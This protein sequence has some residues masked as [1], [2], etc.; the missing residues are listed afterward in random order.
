MENLQVLQKIYSIIYTI[1][2]NAA[3]ATNKQRTTA[4]ITNL[5]NKI[6]NKK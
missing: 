4:T 5:N 3:T 2:K 6:E 1:F